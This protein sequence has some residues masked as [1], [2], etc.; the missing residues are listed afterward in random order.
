MGIF[1]DIGDFFFGDDDP[2]VPALSAAEKKNLDLQNK[3]L[4]EQADLSGML[5]PLILSEDFDVTIDESGNIVSITP[6]EP[7]EAEAGAKEINKLLTEQT[8]KFL[9]GEGE[10]P[11]QVGRDFAKSRRVLEESLRKSL[12]PDFIGSTPGFEAIRDF[13]ESRIGTLEGIRFGRLSELEGLRLAGREAEESVTNQNI[14][15]WLV[16]LGV[17]AGPIDAL[18]RSQALT[19]QGQQLGLQANIAGFSPGAIQGLV[20]GIGTGVGAGS[21]AAIISAFLGKD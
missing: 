6:K 4:Q 13:E 14:Q 1:S 17:G 12:G 5:L 8:L 15:R 18:Q 7:T 21:S 19:L 16:G 10:V 20:Q 11:A 3:L 2:E 9:K